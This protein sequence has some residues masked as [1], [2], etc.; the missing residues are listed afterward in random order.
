M[1]ISSFLHINTS[2]S[3]K[4]RIASGSL[5]AGVGT[6]LG[7]L[8][9]LIAMIMAAR[10][11]GAIGFGT[12]GLVQSTLGVFALFAGAAFGATATRFIAAEKSTD[13]DRVGRIVGIVV[14]GTIFSSMLFV[15]A[16]LILSESLS[17][18]ILKVPEIESA[19]KLGA[20]MVLI[21]VFRGVGDA[22]LAGF[23]RFDRIAVGRVFEGVVAL[24]IL[25][26]LVKSLGVAGGVI[27]LTLSG[28]LA[29]M[30]NVGFALKEFR[31]HGIW[32][33]LTEALSEWRILRDFSLPSLAAS[34]VATPIV[35]VA[36][37]MLGRSENGLGELGLYNAAYQW[38]A[39]I[40]FIP[41]VIS[42]VSLPI[43]AREWSEGRRNDFKRLFLQV[44]LAGF[45]ITGATACVLAIFSNVLLGL[46]GQEYLAAS[47][48][49]IILLMAA[50]LNGISMMASAGIDAI[51]A[52]WTK[53]AIHL[54]WG[55]GLALGAFL[56]IPVFGAAG[57]AGAF[58][59]SYLIMA[60]VKVLLVLQKTSRTYHVSVK[61]F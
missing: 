16:I 14:L 53:V 9:N 50:P 1:N 41:M 21:M 7:R 29:F 18:H 5:W 60:V 61:K 44:A 58:F 26:L 12:F 37:V 25:P 45:A 11:L 34:S 39:P 33:K 51:G 20:L 40:I 32:V 36:M 17:L 4:A 19:L 52:M 13:P 31:R 43:L 54:I 15:A 48:T 35:W 47:V 38:F 57:L 30:L 22:I 42:S 28:G 8:L 56:L 46:M 23:E 2:K 59:I 27:A 10:L 24:A 6:G 55:G 3:L 49:M